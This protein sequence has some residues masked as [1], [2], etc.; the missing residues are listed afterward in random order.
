MATSAQ[1]SF[2]A[3]F[4]AYQCGNWLSTLQGVSQL[5]TI[6]AIHRTGICVALI[7]A[8]ILRSRRWDWFAVATIAA[9]Y[10]LRISG[11]LAR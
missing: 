4:L 6:L 7:L 1:P 2:L 5:T 8:L 9:L 10:V 11:Q 3:Y